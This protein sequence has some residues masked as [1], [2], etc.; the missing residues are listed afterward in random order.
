MDFEVGFKAVTTVTAMSV[1][2]QIVRDTEAEREKA[3]DFL[4]AIDCDQSRKR[5]LCNVFRDINARPARAQI[6]HETRLD[7]TPIRNPRGFFPD[8]R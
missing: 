4:V 5:L 6:A 7:M 1:Y 2:Q 3:A 8:P